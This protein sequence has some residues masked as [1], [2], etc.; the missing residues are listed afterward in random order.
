[1]EFK[2]PNAANRLGFPVV[3][4]SG[5]QFQQS[6]ELLEQAI[7]AINPDAE[8]VL[9]PD[10]GAV[11]NRHI[12]RSHIKDIETTNPVAVAWW[13]Q[14]NKAD[15]DIDEIPNDCPIEFISTDKFLSHCPQ[16]L[17]NVQV[18]RFKDWLGNQVKR[19]KPKGFGAVKPQGDEFSGNRR[20]AWQQDIER[21][22]DVLDGSL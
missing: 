12:A 20:E 17:V 21:R 7:N 9:I 14:I 5:Y 18:K 13:G 1:M 3:G 6:P 2:A 8:L 16:D 15:G 22:Q 10:G 4:F 19:F 11:K